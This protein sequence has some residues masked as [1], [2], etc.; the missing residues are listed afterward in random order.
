MLWVLDPKP[1][2]RAGQYLGRLLQI[3]QAPLHLQAAGV[4]AEAA[5]AA[6]HAVAGDDERDRVARAGRAGGADRAL[7]A[8]DAGEVG[9]GAGLAVGDRGDALAG[10]EE[11]AARQLPVDR[12]LE[13]VAAAG[14]VVVEL[15]PLLVEAGRVLED[16]GEIRPA[17]SASIASVSSPGRPRRTSP[18]GVFASRRG[19]KGESAAA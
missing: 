1:P 8:G 18:R 10:A 5:V 16:A 3:E 13:G 6:E 19:P 14:E 4:T 7:V 17:R 2:G 11:E 12:Q 15:A 9:V